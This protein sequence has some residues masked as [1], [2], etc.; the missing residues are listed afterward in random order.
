MIAIASDHGAYHLKEAVKAHLTKR[1]LVY[2][3]FGTN[4]TESCD[5]PEF[6]AKA[7]RAV[8]AGACD[9]GI[10]LCTTGIGVSIVANKISGIRCALCVTPFMAEMTRRHNDSNVLALGAALNEEAESLAIVDIWLDSDFEGGR[11]Q[12]RVDKITQIEASQE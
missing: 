7:A 12:N 5:Y 4:S 3:D 6:A 9:R 11:H 8:A 1:G 2:E 10:V